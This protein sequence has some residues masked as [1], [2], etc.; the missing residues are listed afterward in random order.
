MAN[1]KYNVGDILML[2]YQHKGEHKTQEE[3]IVILK[4]PPFTYKNDEEISDKYLVYDDGDGK[5]LNQ[6]ISIKTIED[7]RY[8]KKKKI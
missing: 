8:Y 7:E 1:R 6:L 5:K 3:D 2:L 4:V